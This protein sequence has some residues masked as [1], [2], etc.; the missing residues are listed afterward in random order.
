MDSIHVEYP[1]KNIFLCGGPYDPSHKTISS[2]R[3]AF[4]SCCHQEPFSNYD[5]VLAEDI[6]RE[7]QAR[8]GTYDNLLSLES[9]L[10]Q[11]SSITLLFSESFGS[12]AELG[13]FCWDKDISNRLLVV[14]SDYYYAEDS[15]VKL[16]PLQHLKKLCG[17][18]SVCVVPEDISDRNNLGSEDKKYVNSLFFYVNDAFSNRIKIIKPKTTLNRHYQGHLILFLVGVLWYY[19]ALEKDELH[20]IALEVGFN[21]NSDDIEKGMFCATQFNWISIKNIGFRCFYVN[22]SEKNPLSFNRKDRSFSLRDWKFN[23]R[24]FWEKSDRQR[25]DAFKEARKK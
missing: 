18:T 21:V 9:D 22:K 12:A 2:M 17:D 14:I 20:Y 1:T 10:A 25:F 8:Q 3:G 19:Y 4:Y 13:A 16:G 7:F 5:I 11:L 6:S 24:D 23:M 15:F